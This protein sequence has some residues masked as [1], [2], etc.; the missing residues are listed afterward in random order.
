MADISMCMNED[1]EMEKKCY[2]FTARP[3]PYRQAYCYFKPVEGASG[4]EH[5][6]PLPK[7]M[8]RQEFK[9][10]LTHFMKRKAK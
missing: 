5:F 3:N 7:A 1:C 9:T 10:K 6:W 2:R 8:T 4:C